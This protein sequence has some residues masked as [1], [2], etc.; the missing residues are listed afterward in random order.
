MGSCDRLNARCNGMCRRDRSVAL[1]FGLLL[2]L[3]NVIHLESFA[4][5]P[6][7]PAL[8]DWVQRAATARVPSVERHL[9][10][11]ST[12]PQSSLACSQALD[13]ACASNSA[14]RLANA[15]LASC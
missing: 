6:G 10:Q 5:R 3:F 11:C 8:V 9:I 13:P 1:L 14:A 15:A 2:K 4:V 12:P 7:K